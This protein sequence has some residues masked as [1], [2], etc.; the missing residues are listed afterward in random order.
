[1]ITAGHCGNVMSVSGVTGVQVPVGG[2]LYRNSDTNGYDVQFMIESLADLA[3]S[4]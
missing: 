4:D 3:K 2:E 1:M